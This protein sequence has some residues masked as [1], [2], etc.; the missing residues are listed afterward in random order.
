MAGSRSRPRGRIS[1]STLCFIIIRTL[2]V[3]ESTVILVRI[4][5]VVVVV[6]V[7]FVFF[8]LT[9]E[10]E[11]RS[12]NQKPPTLTKRAVKKKVSSNTTIS[13]FFCARAIYTHTRY[14][15]HEYS[16]AQTRGT[17]ERRRRKRGSSTTNSFSLVVCESESQGVLFSLVLQR[18][19]R[20]GGNLV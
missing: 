2:L 18:V 20:S 19:R 17:N 7:P 16:P 15:S 4:K 10:E 3:R 8:C 13:S 12:K 11:K 6:V 14:I 9:S 5:G 1:K